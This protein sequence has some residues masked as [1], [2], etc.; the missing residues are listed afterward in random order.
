M[1]SSSEVPRRTPEIAADRE[2]SFE[3]QVINKEL[4]RGLPAELAKE[5]R[6]QVR[7]VEHIWDAMPALDRD[8]RGHAIRKLTYQS[9]NAVRNLYETASA[10]GVAEPVAAGLAFRLFRGLEQERSVAMRRALE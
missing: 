5:L 6:V 7:N 3:S 1:P 10:A 8:V 2:G 9:W 4:A